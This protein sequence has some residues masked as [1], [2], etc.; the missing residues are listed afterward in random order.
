[1]STTE[2]AKEA[3][4]R[5]RAEFKRLGWTARDVSVRFEHFSLGSS[6]EATIRSEKPCMIV[7]RQILEGAERIRRCEVS[8]E[9]LGGGNRYVSVRHTDEVRDAIGRRH[10]AALEAA[11]AALQARDSEGALEPI[12]GT[13]VS[14]GWAHGK[15]FGVRFWTERAHPSM[16]N[17]PKA[18]DPGYRAWLLDAGY[19]VAMLADAHGMELLEQ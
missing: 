17:L 4:A 18:S 5:I 12:A 7:V 14:V 6:I 8:G 11:L 13:P 10:T 3:A 19:Q 2:T 1:V 16:L 15:G 9:I